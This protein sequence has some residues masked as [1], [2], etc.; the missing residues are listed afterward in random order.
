M[1]H[2]CQRGRNLIFG[3]TSVFTNVETETKNEL[4]QSSH[5]KTT[6]S[7]GRCLTTWSLC[8]IVK[9]GRGLL[10]PEEWTPGMLTGLQR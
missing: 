8:F 1:S 3:L 9:T 10:A 5:P 2:D 7:L 4:V 6:L